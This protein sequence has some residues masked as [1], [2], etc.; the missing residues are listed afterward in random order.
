ML[1]VWNMYLHLSYKLTIHVGK[2]TSPM[3][4]TGYGY[5]LFLLRFQHGGE[6]P[7][8]LSPKTRVWNH[9]YLPLEENPAKQ[10]IALI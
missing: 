9:W 10:L 1:H 7:K 2:Y 4:P 8:E 3:D 5:C 6:P